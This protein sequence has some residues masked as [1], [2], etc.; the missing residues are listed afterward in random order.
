[1]PL[2]IYHCSL[3]VFS[4]SKGHSAVAAAA[5]RSGS[6]L[7]DE[8]TGKLHHY[9]NRKGVLDTFL[10]L[11]DNTDAAYTDRAFLWNSAEQADNRR[12]SR[13]ARELVLALP[14]ELS[15][16]DRQ[17][18]T[19]DMAGWLMERYRVAVD[20]AIHKPIDSHGDDP[21][22]HHAHILFSTRTLTP[23]GFSDKTRILDDRKTGAEETALIR[24]VWETLAN[25]ALKQAGFDDIQI[26]KR[27]LEEQG[28][29]RIPEVH[30]GT[31]ATHKGEPQSSPSESSEEEEEED[32]G[33]ATK[34][35]GSGESG[36]L[37]P[38]TP[39][40]DLDSILSEE[41][42]YHYKESETLTR[43]D[44]NTEIKRINAVRMAYSDIP[45]TEQIKDIDQLLKR[46]DS[47]VERLEAL[48]ERS[49]LSS[50][51]QKTLARSMNEILQLSKEILS[52]KD[53]SQ[54]T[55]ALNA[56][57]KEARSA[58]QLKRY[59]RTYRAGIHTQIK[60]MKQNLS[61]F[62]TKQAD[63]H[64][65]KG[66]VDT[67]DRE[68]TE[69]H[70]IS[71]NVSSSPKTSNKESSLKIALQAQLMRGNIPLEFRAERKS[72]KSNPNNIK[73]HIRND[74][75]KTII[76]TQRIIK[77]RPPVNNLLGTTV[78]VKTED[79]SNQKSV[80]TRSK[81]RNSFANAG[82]VDREILSQANPSW[83]SPP[84]EGG[85]PFD[86]L[87]S[88]K[89]TKSPQ[90]SDLRNTERSSWVTPN[91]EN[92]DPL[93]EA[94]RKRQAQTRQESREQPDYD[95]NTPK[96]QFNE[97]NDPKSHK[98]TTREAY[99][100]KS[101]AEAEVIREGV[102]PEFR[103]EP[104]PREDGDTPNSDNES[105]KDRA[106]SRFKDATGTIKEKW[107]HFRGNTTDSA[108]DHSNK[109]KPTMS[110]GFNSASFEGRDQNEMNDKPTSQERKPRNE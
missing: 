47:R 50:K 13:T 76:S 2:A 4:R 35:G 88:A 97:S 56:Q 48:L 38:S 11:P 30:I 75:S 71:N 96:G 106:R 87:K 21:R 5:Y 85:K 24:D 33:D 79:I 68:L 66:L 58:R 10:V 3:K 108:E 42:T 109:P 94:I 53:T 44:L 67:I 37:A 93:S 19:R 61:I 89:A 55:L 14:H 83:R 102:P 39:T 77:N 25:D 81:P 45:L 17:S 103:A 7:F 52:A 84:K 72:H 110:S 41:S 36:G 46:L 49:S 27:S 23:E 31:D 59:G 80:N 1:M 70:E 90:H 8:R 86:P 43:R 54:A 51:L 101:A 95:M 15:D 26:D 92:M 74:Q 98:R 104:Y 69:T 57:E 78:K 29:D 63:Y 6:K 60:E 73:E 82:K 18:L 32:Q 105:M 62:K 28:V 16:L 99:R 34:G 22:N 9:E 107:H 64:R 91:G 20:A 100:A 65:Y 40:E 12:N